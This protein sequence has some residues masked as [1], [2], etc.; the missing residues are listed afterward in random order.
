MPSIKS[1]SH[2][3][4]NSRFYIQRWI[5]FFLSTFASWVYALPDV[6]TNLTGSTS[7]NIATLEWQPSAGAIG[8]NIYK[9]NAYVTTIADTLYV[10]P[11]LAGQVATYYVVAF[12]AE[13]TEYSAQSASVTLPESAVPDDLTIPPS[14]PEDL[15]GTLIGSDV[16]LS[17]SASTDD[18]AVSGYNIYQNNEYVTTVFA[19]Q[20][21]GTASSDRKHTFYV[22]AFD[23]RNNFSQASQSLLLPLSESTGSPMPPSAP[24]GLTGTYEQSGSTAAIRI[25]WNPSTDDG[26]VIGYNVYQNNEYVTTVFDTSYSTE[27]PADGIYSFTVIAFDNET[28]FS[29]A[30]DRLLLPDT[31]IPIDLSIPPTM[32]TQLTGS[33]TGGVDGELSLTWQAATDDRG[34]AGYNVYRDNRYLTTVFNTE[35][36]GSDNAEEIHEYS[37]VAFDI[38]NNFSPRSAPLLLPQGASAVVD[39]EPPTTPGSLTGIFSDETDTTISLSWDASTDNRSVSG[40]NVYEN[41][42]YLTTVLGTSFQKNVAADSISNY[43]IVAF[44]AAGNFSGQSN[45]IT[46]PDLGNQPPFFAGLQDVTM[47]AGDTLALILSPTDIDGTLPGM[48]TGALPVG[49]I[50]EDNFDGTRTLRWRP[51]QPAVGFYD[52]TVTAIDAIDPSLQNTQ[53]FRLTVELPDDTSGIPNLPP[54]I[55]LIETHVLRT[56]D[57]VVMEVKATDPNGTVPELTLLNQ[58]TGSSFI[59]HPEFPNIKVLRWPTTVA[60]LGTTQ[61]SFMAVDAEDSSM[62]FQSTV[63]LVIKDP[64][65]FTRP[66]VRLKDLATSHNIQLGYASLLQYY[67]RPDADLYQTIA[68]EEFNLVTTENSMKW[69]FVN[70]EPGKFRWEAADRLMAFAAENNMDV[71]GHT[72]VWYASLPQWVQ[73]SETSAREGIMN[74]FIDIMTSRYPDVAIWDVVNEAFEEDGSYRNS[75]WFQ[76]MG[77]DYVHKAFARARLGDPDATLIYNDYNIAYAGPKSD[78]TLQLMQELLAAGAPLDGI[79]FQMHIDSSFDQFDSVADRFAQFAALGIDIYITELDVSMLDGDTEEDQAEVYAAVAELCLAQ[80]ACKALQI[81]G[82]TDRYSWLKPFT[83]LILDEN[84]QIKPAYRALQE[85]LSGG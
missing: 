35:Y 24:D 21:Q 16:N 36:Q 70:P 77:K 44:D 3:S 39:L 37:V 49:M 18:E 51:L 56:G 50:S 42:N 75:V 60:D 79:G 14:V 41:N 2:R 34:V 32:V 33:L 57:T 10:E 30:S 72:L 27:V 11:L 38:D 67:N 40:Y 63:D 82:V 68:R 74:D 69:G 71:H 61:L 55:D 45:K 83:P 46:L 7:N 76:A 78:A 48:F 12:S 80:P 59:V 47:F 54:G 52:I 58:P 5:L 64:S 29:S 6:P 53:T 81:W 1:I 20:W 84:Y 66:G 31:G 73:T 19:T 13:P 17:W 28:L 25:N 22:V 62:Q 65:E 15:T 23:V 85:A 26:L 43:F 9:N 8:Y 4:Y